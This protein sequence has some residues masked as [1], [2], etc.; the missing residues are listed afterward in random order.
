M[1]YLSTRKYHNWKGCE[2]FYVMPKYVK[3]NVTLFSHN[4][5][6]DFRE[7]KIV[8]V[9]LLLIFQSSVDRVNIQRMV[10]LLARKVRQEHIQRDGDSNRQNH[11]H[12]A[13][14]Q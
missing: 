4:R 5:I 11:A 3:S 7:D 6:L 9:G 12:P 2:R 10:Y 13:Q 8:T 1:H 14:Q